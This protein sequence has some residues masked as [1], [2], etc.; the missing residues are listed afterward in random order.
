MLSTVYNQ[1]AKLP[2]WSFCLHREWI[3]NKQM[4]IFRDFTADTLRHIAFVPRC[5]A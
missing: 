2:D 4:Q 5:W 3:V 1:R